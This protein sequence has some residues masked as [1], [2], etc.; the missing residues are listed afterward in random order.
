PNP[1]P[2]PTAPAPRN[3]IASPPPC[4]GAP[5]SPSNSTSAR[6]CAPA[7]GSPGTPGTPGTA[8]TP[9][10]PIPT[11]AG[12]TDTAAWRCRTGCVTCESVEKV[13]PPEP[14]AGGGG[15]GAACGAEARGVGAAGA[16]ARGVGAPGAERGG[17]AA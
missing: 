16:G 9:V 15:V 14:K 2:R 10:P 17:V 8:P 13:R 5:D 1:A 6:D 12:G 3:A 4:P 7:P 11:V